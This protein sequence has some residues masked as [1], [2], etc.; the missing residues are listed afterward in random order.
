MARFGCILLLCV[1]CVLRVCVSVHAATPLNVHIV[2]HT[3]DDVGMFMCTNFTIT[4]VYVCV[5][6]CW[7]C[8][9]CVVCVVC[10]YAFL[11]CVHVPL[12]LYHTYTCMFI[13]AMRMYVCVYVRLLLCV[14][15]CMCLLLCMC[16]CGVLFL[17]VVLMICFVTFLSPLVLL[18]LSQAG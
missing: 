18:S 4:G 13:Y 8:F 6:G 12:L 11:L 2:C 5:F 1:L 9:V 3:H 15:M 14:C 7:F 10:V 17:S 16:V